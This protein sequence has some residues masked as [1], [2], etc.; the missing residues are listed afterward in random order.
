MSAKLILGAIVALGSIATFSLWLFKR[1]W[2][3]DAETRKL[4]KQL[5]QI[6]KDMRMALLSGCS[7]DYDLLGAKRREL[8][9]ELR[10]LHNK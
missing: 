6:R 3:A 1:Y 4:K 9:Q 2:S 7:S 8:L 10:G 5:R